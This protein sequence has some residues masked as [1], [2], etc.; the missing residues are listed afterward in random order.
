MD[1]IFCGTPE[2]SVPPLVDLVKAGHHVKAVFTQPDKRK[3]RGQQIQ[4]TP[5]K[6]EAEKHNIP[7][8][9]PTSLRDP[10]VVELMASFEAD[11]MVVVAYGLIIPQNIL[12]LPQHGCWNIHAS[13]LPR[14]RGAAPIHRAILAGDEETGIAIMQMEAG[15]DTGPVYHMYPTQISTKDT[16]ATL[17]DR[18]SLMGGEAIVACVEQLV[19]ESLPPPEKQNNELATYAHK[20][21]KAESAIDWSAPATHIERQIRAFNPWPG[22]HAEINGDSVKIWAAET[23][24][25]NTEIQPGGIVLANKNQLYIQ[26]GDGQICIQEIQKSGKKRMPIEAFMAAKTAWFNS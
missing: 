3:G 6:I 19:N 22:S 17:H 21:T 12:D 4:K 7:V 8:F 18:L 16:S 20:L 10:A 23:V 1:I 14:W 5:V 25:M 2:F 9:Q 11:L 15:L 13:L 26:T 24:D